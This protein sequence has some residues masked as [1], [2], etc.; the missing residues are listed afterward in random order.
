MKSE[1]ATCDDSPLRLTL[2]GDFSMA[3]DGARIAMP[4]IAQRV[5]A[6]L[7]LRSHPV[8]RSYVSGT[9]W[10]D[11]PEQRAAACLRSAL[12]R[13]PTGGGL[14]LVGA[15]H[16]HVWL[17]TA[18]TV[19]L[20]TAMALATD[21]IDGRYV[22]SDLVDLARAVCAD[23]EDLLI[24][25]YDDWV[26]F[27]RERFR[28]LRLHALD[29]LGEDLLEQ[30]RYFD[31]LHVGLVAASAEPLHES[32]QRLIVRTH[33]AEGNVAAAVRAYTT[34]ARQLERE[35]RVSPSQAMAELILDCRVGVERV[36]PGGGSAPRPHRPRRTPVP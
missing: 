36:E 9:L 16:S 4:P 12:C 7:S 20:R 33:L 2:I 22:G 11:A 19:D 5:V 24:G 21:V 27:E 6:F 10:P 26:I 18:V 17:S 15:S 35:L 23:F 14:P 32:A 8:R 25:W 29:R 3:H 34:Y 30:G 13:V 31:A 1:P 28:Q